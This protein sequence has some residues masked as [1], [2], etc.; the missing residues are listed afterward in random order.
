MKLEP[1]RKITEPAVAEPTN[2]EERRAKLE[3]DLAANTLAIEKIKVERSK[4]F[5]SKDEVIWKIDCIKEDI[6]IF[7][8][9]VKEIADKEANNE[10]AKQLTEESKAL[11]D[12]I[13]K[14]RE[15]VARIE[16]EHDDKVN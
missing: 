1:T 9:E 8:E 14:L 6:N 11:K 16:K 15:E 2:N 3:A 10:D 7:I 4:L 12:E 13:Y 5:N